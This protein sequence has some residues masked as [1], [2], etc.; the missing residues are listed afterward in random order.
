MQ[1]ELDS[2]NP[3]LNINILGVNEFGHESGNSQIIDG[4]DLPWL[5]DIDDNG[6]GASDTWDSWDV[7]FRDV[8]ITDAQNEKVAVYNLTTNDLANTDNFAALKQLLIDSA[9]T[10]ND[11]GLKLAAIDNQSLLSGSPLHVPLNGLDPSVGPL[12]FSV[13]SSDPLVSTEVLTGN[14]SLR[15]Q[16]DDFGVMTFELFESRAPRVTSRIIELVESGV[17][18]DTIFHRVI[19]DFVLQGGDP[20]GTGM[21]DPTLDAFDDQFH[22]DLQFNRTGLIGMAKTTDDTNTSQFFITEGAS[23]HLDFNHSIFGILTEGEDVREAISEVATNGVS[24]RPLTDVVLHEVD[25]FNDPENGVLVLSAAEGATGTATITV[26]VTDQSGNTAVQTFDVTVAADTNNGTPFLDDIAAVRMEANSQTTFTLSAQDVEGDAVEFLGEAE[27]AA[28]LSAT[29]MPDLPTGLAYTV[30]S[31]TGVVTVTASDDLIGEHQFRVGVRPPGIAGSDQYTIDSQLVSITLGVI[32][33]NADDHPSGSDADNGTSDTF[34]LDRR[35]NTYVISVNGETVRSENEAIVFAIDLV[36]SSDDDVFQIDCSGGPPIPAGGV[37]IAGKADLSSGDSLELDGGTFGSITHRF[38]ELSSGTISIESEGPV[39]YSGIE[40]ID[41]RL[42]ASVSP[43]VFEFGDSDDSIAVGDDSNPSNEFSKISR[44]SAGGETV[45]FRMTPGGGRV[46]IRG[47]RGD[48]QIVAG[49]LDGT[50]PSSLTVSGDS[51]NDMIDASSMTDSVTLFG[52]QGADRLIGGNNDDKLRGQGGSLDTLTG[53]PGNDTLDGGPGF[54]QV[55]ESKDSDFTA[56]DTELVGAGTDVLDDIQLLR[57]D[58]GPG[59]NA[60][61]GSAFTGRLFLN[62]RGGQDTLTGGPGADRLFGGAGRDLIVGGRHSDVLFGQGG[63][64]DTLL[65]EHGNDKLNG[66][67]GNDDLS[68]GDGDDTLSGEAGNDSLDGGEGDDQVKERSDGDV[69]VTDVLLTDSGDTNVLT[70]VET[71]YLRGGDS[72]NLF[73]GS[74]F[75]GDMTLIGNAGDD[76]LK[77]GAGSD[78]L[79]GNHGNDSIVG[80]GG[81]DV[82]MGMRGNDTLAGEMG[83]D[84]LEGGSGDD[85]LRGSIGNDLLFG[86]FGNDILI[87]GDGRDTII[88]GSGNDGLSG[89]PGDDALNGNQGDDSLFGGVGDDTMF[90]GGGTD[91]LLGEDG[92]DLINGNGKQDV[93][94]GGSG[95]DTIRD[96]QSEIDE[97]FELFVD[98][99]DAT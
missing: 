68:G 75:S 56:S 37:Q 21:G 8:I 65:G 72:S 60:L 49:V 61:D 44:E 1:T 5:Q 4:R 48:D 25:V 7:T 24:D 9:S 11:P 86:H 71:L 12:T 32:T 46:V 3:E 38:G 82:L 19:D 93:V 91:S 67:V 77:G 18:T 20:T 97:S 90:G 27:L 51:G 23:R 33:V 64:R 95:T 13:E 62:G 89:G 92:N 99:I 2:E 35:A 29:Q 6:D 76:T 63:N 30:D 69:T 16:V 39:I 84:W 14:R 81:N 15:I 31:T 57:L 66:G 55:I 79:G 85:S 59:N 78:Y 87:G 26:T 43:R 40:F 80:N 54:D 96:P 50:Y 36:G 10:T 74:A 83:D 28:N 73:D 94:S 34:L 52:G 88:A 47:G 17:Y 22:V 98:W 45:Q 53:G 42:N 70:S 58:G 41:N